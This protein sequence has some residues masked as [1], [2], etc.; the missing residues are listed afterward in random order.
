MEMRVMMELLAPRMEHRQAAN[1]GPKMLRVPRDV[2]EC[3]HHGA[4]QH[5][6][7]QAGILEAQGTEEMWQREHDM[8]VGDVEHLTLP[9]S[10]PGRLCSPVALGAVAIATGVIAD[11]LVAALITLGFVA[12]KGSRAA[13]GDSA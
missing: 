12:P 2:L 1:L 6:I 5:A 4:T 9:G 10:K 11:F 3:L 8:D 13:A 7:E